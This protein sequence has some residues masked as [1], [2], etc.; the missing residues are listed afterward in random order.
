MKRT[1]ILLAAALLAAGA[2]AGFVLAGRGWFGGRQETKPAET[3][4]VIV[5]V[6]VERLAAPGAL[7]DG[8]PFGSIV[9]IQGERFFGTAHGPFVRFDGKD[10][11]A[12]IID[13]DKAIRAF[14]P[15]GTAGEVLVEVENPDHQ[16]AA[17]KSRFE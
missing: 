7:P 11:V 5:R 14:A 3:A 6:D 1:P 4:P 17:V 8:R 13:S 16:K 10:A 9:K 15:V 12:V 2:T